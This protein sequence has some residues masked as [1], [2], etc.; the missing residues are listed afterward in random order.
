MMMMMMMMMCI[1]GFGARDQMPR[2]R[3]NP[4]NRPV[5]QPD[6][7]RE[8]VSRLSAAALA[9]PDRN[10][11]R[12]KRRR[13]DA[14][15]E[16]GAP[17]ATTLPSDAAIPRCDLAVGV[18]EVTRGLENGAISVVSCHIGQCDFHEI[19]GMRCVL[20]WESLCHEN[21]SV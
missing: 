3:L 8:I 21:A 18:N 19:R 11:L 13:V 15:T 10:R 14:S 6:D 9:M 5:I 17:E 4:I 1:H 16:A 12:S 20:E 2:Y 7:A